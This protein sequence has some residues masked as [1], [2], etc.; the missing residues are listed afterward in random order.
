MHDLLAE[1]QG[2]V[3][4]LV[5]WMHAHTTRPLAD[6]VILEQDLRGALAAPGGPRRTVMDRAGRP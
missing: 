6:L 1:W 2:L 4:P 3:E 5:A